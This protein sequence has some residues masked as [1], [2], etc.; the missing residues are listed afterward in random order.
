M[1]IINIIGNVLIKLIL[2][3]ECR[4]LYVSWTDVNSKTGSR[5][6]YHPDL[7]NGANLNKIANKIQEEENLD[8]VVILNWSRVEI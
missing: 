1:H 7:V 8:T 4:H 2:G 6:F 5:C 3:K